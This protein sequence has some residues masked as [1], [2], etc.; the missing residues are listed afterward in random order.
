MPSRAS[1]FYSKNLSDAWT[2]AREAA[3]SETAAG[4]L[5]IWTIYQLLSRIAQENVAAGITEIKPAELPKADLEEQ[6]HKNLLEEEMTE[7]LEKYE[8]NAS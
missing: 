8:R 2:K 7:E 5:M 6:F 1:S 4:Q 3:A